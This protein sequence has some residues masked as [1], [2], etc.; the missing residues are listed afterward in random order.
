MATDEGFINYSYNALGS[1]KEVKYQ[2][3]IAVRLKFLEKGKGDGMIDEADKVIGMLM[4]FIKHVS[5]GGE[6]E[7]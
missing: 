7:N 2:L 5:D 1:A 3:M 4:R 6:D